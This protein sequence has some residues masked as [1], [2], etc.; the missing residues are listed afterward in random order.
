M[1]EEIKTDEI[2]RRLWM[3]RVEQR[4]KET[5][6]CIHIPVDIDKRTGERRKQGEK[7]KFER[8]KDERCAA[9]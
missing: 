6:R 3:R 9:E 2:D 5:R 4:R 7:R 8:R 1:S